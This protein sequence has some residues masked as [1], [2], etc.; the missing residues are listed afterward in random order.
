M[1]GLDPP[2]DVRHTYVD[3]FHF[4]ADLTINQEVREAGG[5]PMSIVYEMRSIYAIR[6]LHSAAF[7]LDTNKQ[8]TSPEVWQ[9]DGG[10][11]DWFI[12][13]ANHWLD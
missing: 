2:T 9:A 11:D 8:E 4:M 12:R 6:R 13:N 1:S 3:P 5:K 7:F 10:F